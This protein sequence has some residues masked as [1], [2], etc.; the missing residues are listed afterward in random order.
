VAVLLVQLRHR[1]RCASASLSCMSL[2]LLRR[3]HAEPF[4]NRRAPEGEAGR[5]LAQPLACDGW[6]TRWC[7]RK[8][9]QFL[10]RFSYSR[11]GLFSYS[12]NFISPKRE[13]RFS[14]CCFILTL[15]PCLFQRREGGVRG[16]RLWWA[17]PL[18]ALP[19]A[20]SFPSRGGRAHCAPSQPALRLDI[21][22]RNAVQ[23][24]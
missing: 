7:N 5:T 22:C 3:F 12:E 9:S 10:M 24:A 21:C 4:R 16:R 15:F 13:A 20:L 18:L 6:L 2:L 17:P 19:A 1:R 8:V 11:G 14:R 23:F